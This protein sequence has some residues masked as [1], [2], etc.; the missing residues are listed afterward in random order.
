MELFIL[1]R[2]KKLKIRLWAVFYLP[3]IASGIGLE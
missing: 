1:L 3:L 2:R